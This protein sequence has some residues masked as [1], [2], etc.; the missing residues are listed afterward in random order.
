MNGHKSKKVRVNLVSHK[1]AY[2]FFSFL[3]FCCLICEGA[4]PP[5]DAELQVILWIKKTFSFYV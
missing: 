2:P 1:G 4:E 3:Y 5:A